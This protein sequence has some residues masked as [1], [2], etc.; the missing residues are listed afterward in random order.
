MWCKMN[1]KIK[2]NIVKRE[3]MFLTLML[4]VVLISPIVLSYGVLT[5][6]TEDKPMHILPGESG[7]TYMKIQNT[8][9]QAKNDISVSVKLIDDG[10]IASIDRSIY[11]VPAGEQLIIPI[12]VKIPTDA[13]VGKEYVIIYGVTPASPEEGDGT[14]T[15]G[16]GYEGDFKI[17]IVDQIISVGGSDIGTEKTA[18][19]N[20]IIWIIVIVVILLLFWFLFGRKKN[21]VVK[22]DKSSEKGKKK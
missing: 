11:N 9:P 19:S 15:F 17:K 1:N 8:G 4:I 12:N 2:S 22:S 13:D 6:F 3:V 5:E 20:L 10:G 7:E 14:V 18:S 16:I 21:R